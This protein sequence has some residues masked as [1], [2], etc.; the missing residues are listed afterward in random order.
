MKGLITFCAAVLILAAGSAHAD[1]INFDSLTNHE[2]V[3][4]Q[5]ILELGAGFNGSARISAF[6]GSLYPFHSSPNVIEN[7]NL[8]YK[9]GDIKIDAVGTKW[10][11]AGGYVTGSAEVILTAYD[12]SNTKLVNLS[13]PYSTGGANL[14]SNMFLQF[15]AANID[16]VIFSLEI[17]EDEDYND[18]DIFT[19][20]D[21]TFNPV[22]VPAAV[23]LGMLGLSV[24]GLKLRKFV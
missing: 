13:V 22:P 19:V 7:F 15:M 18:N 17:A 3:D 20:D 5:Y 1:M 6:P 11:M 10:L 8:D 2:L 9:R 16:Y 12:S 4:N 14:G 23:L 21:F 24:A